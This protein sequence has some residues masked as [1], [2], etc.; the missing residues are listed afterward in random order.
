MAVALTGAGVSTESGLPDFRSP[1]GLWADVDPMRVA[2][3]SAFRRDPG[4]F[5]AFYQDRLSRL[6]GA[7]P[8]HA[9]R[10]LADLE[11][12]GLLRAVITQN[13]DGLHQA[14]GSRRVLELH[15]S[16]RRAACPDCGARAD[17]AVLTDALAAGRQ[18]HCPVCAGP[19]KPDVVLFG[20]LLPLTVFAE[21]DALCREADA[22]LVVG[23]SLTVTPAA[24]L[25]QTLLDRGGRLIIVNRE[26]TPYDADAAVVIRDDAGRALP[27]M[28]ALAAGA[29][30]ETAE[31]EHHA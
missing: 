9:H 5:Y 27:A 25:P 8:N 20:E 2:S 22:L 7:Q 21:A 12:G 15:G 11:R 24:E 4:A 1:G 26:P 6:G 19:L 23:S 31:E 10:A 16:L 14:A 29:V 30:R 17:I 28:A 18:P 13:V 3:L